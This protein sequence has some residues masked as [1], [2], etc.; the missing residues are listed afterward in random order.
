MNGK[1][2]FH[3]VAA[4]C[5]T[6]GYHVMR[7]LCG[8][9][10]AAAIGSVACIDHAPV[11]EANAITCPDYAGQIGR[12]KA[13]RLAELIAPALREPPLVITRRV[14]EIDWPRLLRV[15]QGS[16]AK[17]ADVLVIM[18]LDDWQSRLCLV[19]DVRHAA[20]DYAGRIALVQ[21]ALDRGQ[22]Q[23]STFGS[24]WADPCPAC[25]LATLP[26]SEP[27]IAL[28]ADGELLRG[29][30]RH[31]A[32]AAAEFVLSLFSGRRDDSAQWRWLNTK[33]NLIQAAD[34]SDFHAHTRPRVAMPSCWGPHAATTPLQL[35]TVL[36]QEV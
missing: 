27:C 8:D 13:V 9:A 35:S 36:A 14:E 11:R 26:R 3:L 23:V 4:G 1:P 18:G 33:T 2:G 7:K 20:V 30:L 31:E 28:S 5:G 17:A 10:M 12:D 29:D 15:C 25:G 32:L 22:A 21:V 16:A 6:A 34:G 24:D 19:E